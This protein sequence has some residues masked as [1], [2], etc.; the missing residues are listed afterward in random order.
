MYNQT[1]E[2][3]YGTKDTLKKYQSC[4]WVAH[5]YPTINKHK[6][7]R[8]SLSCDSQPSMPKQNLPFFV[9]S[10]PEKSPLFVRAF[11]IL[12]H[13]LRGRAYWVTGSPKTVSVVS[14]F[15]CFFGQSLV[16]WHETISSHLWKSSIE[17]HRLNWICVLWCDKLSDVNYKVNC[18]TGVWKRHS[19][20]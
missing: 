18:K 13:D 16:P 10:L 4:Y 14:V 8:F 12:K 19:F 9:S 1:K 5:L 2:F 20:N 3:K 15:Q 6:M 11:Y 7:E 17:S